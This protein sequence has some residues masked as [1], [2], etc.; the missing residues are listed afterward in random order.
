VS[1]ITIAAGSLAEKVAARAEG[2]SEPLLAKGDSAVHPIMLTR[3]NIMM[4]VL[5]ILY[6]VVDVIGSVNLD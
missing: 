1:V 4:N 5:I 2:V 6:S 3:V